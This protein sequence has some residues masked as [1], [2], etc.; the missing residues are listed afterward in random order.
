VVWWGYELELARPHALALIGLIVIIVYLWRRAKQNYSLVSSRLQSLSRGT[1]FPYGLVVALILFSIAASE[2]SITVYEHVEVNI[3]NIDRVMDV[4]IALVVA[5]DTSKSMDYIDGGVSRMQMT[6]DFLAK[7][8]SY[9]GNFTIV[10]MKFSGQ[11]ELMYSGSPVNAT[12]IIEGLT[13]GERYSAIGDAIG[14]AVS[15][16]RVSGLPTAVIVVTDGGWNY[17]SDPVQAALQA[18]E[19]GVPVAFVLVGS[20]ARGF[21]LEERLRASGIRVYRLDSFTYNVLDRLAEQVA[22][23][24]R[25]EALKA[26]GQAEIEIPVGRKSFS[27]LLGLTGAFLAAIFLRARGV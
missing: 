3:A 19:Q 5:V 25:L 1:G 26:S 2:P 11:V 12:A 16:A 9:A 10:L 4:P 20:D 8:A 23:N 6:K 18:E 24:A 13:G 15:Y 14:A 27:W 22:K 17:G 21:R 7:L